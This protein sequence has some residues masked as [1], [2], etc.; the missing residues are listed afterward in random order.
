MVEAE[1]VVEAEVG[2]EVVV[3][4]VGVGSLGSHSEVSGDNRPGPSRGLS[5]CW[6]S[7]QWPRE[8]RCA[9]QHEGRSP[10][11]VLCPHNTRTNPAFASYPSLPGEEVP[12]ENCSCCVASDPDPWEYPLAGK[13]GRYER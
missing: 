9:C 2:D 1:V 7:R 10:Q 4:L 6:S 12:P 13:W 8:L 5:P 3:G 11:N